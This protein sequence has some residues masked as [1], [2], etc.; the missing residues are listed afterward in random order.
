[1]KYSSS[2]GFA[3]NLV[4]L[5]K[6]RSKTLTYRIDDKYSFLKVGDIINVR[7]SSNDQ[8]F[9]TV[10]ILNI[11]QTTFGE[12]PIDRVGHEV[13]NSKEEQ[14]KTFEG[15]YNRVVSDNEPILVF[16]FKFKEIN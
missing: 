10:E 7:D 11:S 2:I 1:M 15:Y 3:P 4:T 8:I 14:R 13:Y 16:E 6:S 12:L 5:I 9:G